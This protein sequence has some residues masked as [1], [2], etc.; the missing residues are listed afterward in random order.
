MA[1]R[2]I[3]EILREIWALSKEALAEALQIQKEKGGSIGEV[4]IQRGAITEAD[5]LK[6]L[7]IQFGLPLWPIISTEDMDISFAQ[8]I[9]IQ[10]LKKYKMVPVSTHDDGAY[11]A[12]NDPMAF[13]P[14]DDLRLIMGWDGV[15]TVLASHS[16]ILSAINIS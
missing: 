4:L 5:L 9:P 1:H 16:A 15:K 8:H 12:V 10:F 2:L 14:L 13:Q 11:I 7:G 6:A 3:G